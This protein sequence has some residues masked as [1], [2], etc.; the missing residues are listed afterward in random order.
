MSDFLKK[1]EEKYKKPSLTEPMTIRITAEEDAAVRDLADALDCTRQ[2]LIRG[3]IIEYLLPARKQLELDGTSADADFP[4]S[5]TGKLRYYVLNTNKTHDVADHDF[6]LNKGVA[7][8]FEDGYKEKINRFKKGDMI[9]LYESGKGIVAY[10]NAEGNTQ[11]APHNGREDKTHY[12][13]LEGFRKLHKSLSPKDIRR[14]LDRNIK[15]VQALTYLSD[16]EVLLAE[17]KSQ[18]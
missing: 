16:G 18:A 6:M 14:V 15:F 2:E 11:K 13:T 12:Q 3:L 7:A 8:A 1:L 9:F 4:Q 17:L 5:E 10:G